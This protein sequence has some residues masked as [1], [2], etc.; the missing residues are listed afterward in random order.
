MGHQRLTGGAPMGGH[1][2]GVSARDSAIPEICKLSAL[3]GKALV[4]TSVL[5]VSD[6][7]KPAN[8]EGLL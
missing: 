7:S 3:G 5:P 8:Q 2:I 1:A 6:T 4:G